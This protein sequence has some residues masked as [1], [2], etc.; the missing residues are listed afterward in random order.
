LGGAKETAGWKGYDLGMFVEVMFSVLSNT[1]VVGPNVSPW[2]AARKGPLNCGHCFLVIDPERLTPGFE[3]QL[4]PS[5]CLDRMRNLPGDNVPVA[6]DPKKD[7][8]RDVAKNGILLHGHVAATLKAL[9][10]RCNVGIPPKLKNL[11]ETKSKV[12]L[13]CANETHATLR[14]TV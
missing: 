14:I 12:S 4:S 13:R 11:V 5:R 10:Q 8:E 9:A 7:F 2:T 6:G 1:S 3:N